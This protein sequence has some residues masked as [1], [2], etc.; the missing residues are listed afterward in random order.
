[1]SEPDLVVFRGTG[2][3][4]VDGKWFNREALQPHIGI[5]GEWVEMVPTG[6][7]EFREDGVVAEVF[8]PAENRGSR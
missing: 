8:R 5:G 3:S 1:M 2:F 4:D 7:F 6:E